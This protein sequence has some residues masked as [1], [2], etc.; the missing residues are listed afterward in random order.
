MIRK[1]EIANKTCPILHT[2]FFLDAE[3]YFFLFKT[4]AESQNQSEAGRLGCLI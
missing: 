3:I 4:A 2:V 1:K